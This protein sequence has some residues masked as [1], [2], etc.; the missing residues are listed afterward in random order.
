VPLPD[1]EID[2]AP[3]ASFSDFS[4]DWYA[5]VDNLDYL[6]TTDGPAD[7]PRIESLA[8]VRDA[9]ATSGSGTVSDIVLTDDTISF[10]TTA[11]GVPHL[12][13]VSYFPNWIADG[14][15]GPYRSTP[16]LMVVVPTQEQVTL[17]FQNTW[18]EWAG[19]GLTALGLLAV[20]AF[21]V[22]RRRET[23]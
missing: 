13:K 16:S 19:I 23:V 6:V 2:G 7:W 9:D 18:V 10:T 4:I 17:R 5:D 20:A 11:V 21:L 12:V 15:D 22:V 3:P 14:A 1:E 8:E